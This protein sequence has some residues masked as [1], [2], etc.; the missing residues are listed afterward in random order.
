MLKIPRDAKIL[1]ISHYDLDGAGCQIVLAN[2]FDNVTF[3]STS[4]YN[5][6]EKLE[7]IDYSKYDY[8]IIT[9]V[10]PENKNLLYLSDK[11]ILIDHHPSDM[12][13]P[14]NNHFV[15]DNKN[16][17]ATTLTKHF[18]EKMFNEKLSHLDE[19]V[20]LVN[21][22]D[23]WILKDKRSK[24][25]NDLMFHKYKV[26]KF[27]Q[28]FIDGRTEFTDDELKWLKEYDDK[29]YN[30]Y[31]TLDVYEFERINACIVNSFHFINEIA[32]KLMEEEKYSLVVVRNPKT[33]RASVRCQLESLDIG[34][35]LDDFGWGG[36]HSNS[37]GMF[38]DSLVD[39]RSKIEAL[40]EKLYN[41]YVDIRK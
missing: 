38:C 2:V 40:E 41:D 6:D 19:F 16:V 30:M 4:F 39:F 15:I 31:D 10:H 21:D 24:Q 37:A 26:V 28:S 23:M 5:I 3:I 13:D 34:K 18:F 32:H 27:R 8:V 20:Y 29:F 14:N 17:C 35:V 22:Y 1:S 36:G 12:H 33:E 25:L 7:S 9:D 11:I